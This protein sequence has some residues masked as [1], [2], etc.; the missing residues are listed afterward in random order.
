MK[1]SGPA[2]ANLC[3]FIEWNA[4]AMERKQRLANAFWENAPISA[5]LVFDWFQGHPRVLAAKME[6]ARIA[7]KRY[8]MVPPKA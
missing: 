1:D 8:G 2:W 6:L 5:R 7:N 3:R 4:E